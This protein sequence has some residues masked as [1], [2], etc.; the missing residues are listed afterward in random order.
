M[1]MITC[2]SHGMVYY[3]QV[4][5][6]GCHTPSLYALR[7]VATFFLIFLLVIVLLLFSVLGFVLI[8]QFIGLLLVVVH[9]IV[10]V[11]DGGLALLYFLLFLRLL[12]VSFSWR[13]NEER[14]FALVQ[15]GHYTDLL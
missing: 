2:I 8:F 12:F 3:L 1:M 5:R 13:G 7:L 4:N 14:K 9:G 11:F 15:T 6:M 10:V